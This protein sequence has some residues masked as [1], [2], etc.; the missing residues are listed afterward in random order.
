[1]F[2]N[3]TRSAVFAL[4]M[5]AFGS[6]DRAAASGG[7]LRVSP[8]GT[9]IASIDP[10]RAK[11]VAD[12]AI[13]SWMFNGLVRF[14]PGS[15][16]ASR[17]QP[18]LAE[19]WSTSQDGKV[20]VFKLRQG[21]KFHGDWGNFTSRDAAYSLRRAADKARSS[22]AAAYDIIQ[23]LETPDDNTLTIT[24]KRP[25]PD[26][27]GLLSNFEGGNIVS[28][29]AAEAMGDAFSSRP[30]G[31]GPFVFTEHV[32]QQHVKLAAHESYFR[33]RPRLGGIVARFVAS[34]ATRELAFGAGELDVIYGR[35]YQRWVDSSRKNNRMVLD[36]F[37]PGEFRALHLN[38]TIVP[39]DNVKV[40]LAIAHAINV[41]ELRR[42]VG[43]DITTKGCSVVPPSY[44]G[45]DC[46]TGGYVFDLA[47]AKAL[48]AEAGHPDGFALKAVVSNAPSQF[49]VMEIVQAQLAK[50][51]IRLTMDV[52]DHPT[53]H[54]LIRKNGSALV[55][56]GSARFPIA[57]T[58]LSEFYHSKAIVGKPQ[59]VT[60]FSHCSAADA[61]TDAARFELDEKARLALWKTAQEK[62]HA[63]VC[64]VPLFDLLQVWA[65]SKRVSYGF[66]LQ[67]ALSLAPPIDETTTLAA[68]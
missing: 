6:A 30:I 8:G 18:D 47:K 42:F 21:V 44:L 20:W 45:Q 25:D 14:A 29:K 33:G 46:G 1:M 37:R 38:R 61:E 23:A 31:T 49:P 65:H 54:E 62:I 5:F 59:A 13:V 36:I 12:K 57:D 19:S 34:D 27:L 3:C 48:L 24:L 64:A 63:D 16:D 17:L 2:G 55:F 32:T 41:D 39:L 9:D 28:Q 43:A 11:T 26:F 56:Y 50:A 10:H 35:R 67:G 4:A 15:A 53:Y 7:I 60:N 68:R 52:V 58:F 22:F 51:G 66:D 40:R